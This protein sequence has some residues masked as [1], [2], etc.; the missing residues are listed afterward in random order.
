MSNRSISSAF[1]SVFGAKIITI[2]IGLISTPLIARLLGTAKYGEYATVLSIFGITQ[3]LMSS[4]ITNAAQAYFGRSRGE[5]WVDDVWNV[6][7]RLAGILA[8]ITAGLFAGVAY[9][10]VVERHLGQEYTVLFY[11]LAAYAIAMQYS[12]L[13]RRA[14]MGLKLERYSEPLTILKR[15]S[16]A[17]LAVGLAYSGYGVVGVMIG[18]IVSCTLVTSAGIYLLRGQLDLSSTFANVSSNFSTRN[19]LF[20]NLGSILC[21]FFISTLYHIDILMLRLTVSETEIGYYRAALVLVE[22]LWIAPQSLQ[23]VFTHTVADYWDNENFSKISELATQTTR[24]VSL[25]TILL[26]FGLAALSEIFVP[27]YFGIEYEPAI[28]PLLILLPGTVAFAIARPIFGISQ[29]YE[30]LRPVVVA[31][32]VTAII[33]FALNLVLIPRYGIEGAAIAT[34]I[35]YSCL[36]ITQ[37][38]CAKY[39][40]YSP[41]HWKMATR[42]LLTSAIAGPLI[43]FI[44]YSIEGLLALVIVPPV[45]GIIYLLIALLTNAIPRQDVQIAKEFLT[46]FLA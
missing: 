22:M 29:S 24:Y 32:G 2:L 31:T 26:A 19:L 33:N 6:L 35:G 17:G 25:L 1:G 11:L 14:L 42:I 9:F 28:S 5:G 40:G 13:V 44:A 7:F 3:I 34:T 20:F 45:G 27:L 10:G 12:G 16:F 21:A 37:V 4:G 36:P 15:L 23:L 18:H 8:L 39:L 46:S 38:I 30:N 43:I 41:V